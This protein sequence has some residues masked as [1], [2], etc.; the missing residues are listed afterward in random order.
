MKNTFNLFWVIALQAVCLMPSAQVS[1]ETPPHYSILTTVRPAFHA[2]LAACARRIHYPEHDFEQALERFFSHSD[3]SYEN[4]KKW[5]Q[6]V[7]QQEYDQILDFFKAQI[8]AVQADNIIRVQYAIQAL[9]ILDDSEDVTVLPPP[10]LRG[11][12]HRLRDEVDNARNAV[13]TPV[14]H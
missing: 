1:L 10:V 2:T 3:S 9:E 5:F 11:R 7:T 14:N 12:V 6:G 13:R 8:D 4:F